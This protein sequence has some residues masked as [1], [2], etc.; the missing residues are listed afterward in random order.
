MR[1]GTF[2]GAVAAG[3]ARFRDFPSAARRLPA[4]MKTQPVVTFCTGGIRCEKAAPLLQR[5]GF[6]NVFQLDGGI[7]AYFERCGGAH[8]EG[9]CFVFDE[10]TSL[11]AELRATAAPTA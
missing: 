8:Y 7:L 10:R 6:Q 11:D 5:E 1:H 4:E 3:I 2:R 9:E